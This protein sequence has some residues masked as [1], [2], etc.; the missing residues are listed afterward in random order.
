MSKYFIVCWKRSIYLLECNSAHQ[1]DWRSWDFQLQPHRGWCKPRRG[2]CSRAP[3]RLW[4]SRDNEIWTA[5]P[6]R[7]TGWR[8]STGSIATPSQSSNARRIFCLPRDNT[9]RYRNV[10]RKKS[11]AQPWGN[12]KK[13]NI[14]IILAFSCSRSLVLTISILGICTKWGGHWWCCCGCCIRV[15]ICGGRSCITGHCCWT[16]GSIGE[17][18]SSNVSS[19]GCTHNVFPAI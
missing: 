4:A 13:G 5:R 11:A 17:L 9:H 19:G 1:S 14:C 16:V 3:G 2:D 7:S 15:E 12:V 10:V 18:V 6:R 8:A